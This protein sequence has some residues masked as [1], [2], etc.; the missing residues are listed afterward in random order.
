MPVPPQAVENLEKAMWLNRDAPA[1]FLKETTNSLLVSVKTERVHYC[2][3]PHTN[4]QIAP[5]EHT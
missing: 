2:I 5:E 3:R 4:E 1:G